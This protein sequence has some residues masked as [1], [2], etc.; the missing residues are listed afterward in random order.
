MMSSGSGV[1]F[2]SG[3]C[4]SRAISQL[5]KAVNKPIKR[6][7]RQASYRE[8]IQKHGNAQRG[9][10]DAGDHLRRQPPETS[11]S[12]LEIEDGITEIGGTE[13]GPIRRRNPQLGVSQ[14]PKK[15]I[16]QAVFT[17]CANQQI[18]VRHFCGVQM[19]CEHFFINRVGGQFALCDFFR[20]FPRGEVMS[21]RPP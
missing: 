3:R 9:C 1:R 2:A 7:P 13:I 10:D 6:R 20:N 17:A 14:L 11:I 18:R 19:L 21:A 4:K 12:A 8:R 5:P 15:E 16:A